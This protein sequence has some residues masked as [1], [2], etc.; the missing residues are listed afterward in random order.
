MD[1]NKN[2]IKFIA[3]IFLFLS[4]IGFLEFCSLRPIF[5]QCHSNCYGYG[6]Y[7]K[8]L[9]CSEALCKGC[10]ECGQSIG[11]FQGLG[12]LGDTL[13][14]LTQGPN[15]PLSLLNKIISILIG[16]ISAIAFI[17][18][19]FVFFTG[20]LSWVSSGGDP[21]SIEKA[22][23]Q[24]TNGIVGLIVVVAAIFITQLLGSI[25]GIDILNPLGFIIDIWK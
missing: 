7:S 18:F 17:Y 13:N 19:I 23:K 1:H 8:T 12:P 20:G 11:K 4:V 14:W 5:A 24:I 16:I 10:P 22:Q 15:E 6:G 9:N 3:R 2:F 25:L 21:K